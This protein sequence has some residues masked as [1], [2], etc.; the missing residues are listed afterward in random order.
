MILSSF[1]LLLLHTV[2]DD[3]KGRR[4]DLDGATLFVPPAFHAADGKAIDLLVHLHGAAS[5]V[6]PA[7]VGAAWPGVLIEFNRNGLSSVY[8][9][10]FKDP[11]LLTNLMDKAMSALKANGLVRDPRVGRLV[12]STFSAGFGGLRE[13]LKVPDHVQRIDAIIMADSL[14][15]GYQGDPD[16]HRVDPTLMAPFHRYA[17]LAADGKKTF[18]LT[19]SSQVPEG[20]ASTT[21]TA[22]DL[23]IRTK[24]S[25]VSEAIDWG[26]DW[27]PTRR[28]RKGRFEVLGFQGA[29]PDDHMRHLRQVQ[30]VWVEAKALLHGQENGAR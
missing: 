25:P 27:G 3:P 22:D 24:A 11:R 10:P 12:I 29:G 23:I 13:I 1:A 2:Q 19:H 17:D 14:Y 20:Y 7:F 9:A 6:E 18:L 30:K 16:D 4:I 21:E 28:V 8:S 15:C 26:L 5:V